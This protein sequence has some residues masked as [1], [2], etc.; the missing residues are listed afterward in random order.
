ML[1]VEERP[2]PDSIEGL[3]RDFGFAHPEEVLFPIPR[4]EA[5]GVI[6]HLTAYD[7]AYG[8]PTGVI[9]IAEECG[10]EFVALFPEDARFFTNSSEPIGAANRSWHPLTEATFDAGVLAIAPRRV[11]VLWFEDED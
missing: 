3:L 7:Q 2:A 1:R 8:A 6:S 10:R 11:G 5:S 4:D 9:D